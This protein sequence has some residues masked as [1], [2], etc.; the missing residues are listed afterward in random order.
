[1]VK[2]DVL[3]NQDNLRDNYTKGRPTIGKAD[4][5]IFLFTMQV[6]PHKASREIQLV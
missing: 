5:M 2:H 1:M 3:R 6:N 4:H